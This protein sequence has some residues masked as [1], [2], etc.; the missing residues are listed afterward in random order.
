VPGFLGTC[1]NVAAGVVEPRSGCAVTPAATCGQDGRCDGAGACRRY[2][3]DTQC[4]PATC[5]R[6]R[7]F[8][9]RTCDGAGVCVE[10]GVVTCMM[11]DCDPATGRCP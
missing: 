4:Q 5:D 11:F 1:S 2:P 3:A 8:N 6:R 9:P 7:S 10:R